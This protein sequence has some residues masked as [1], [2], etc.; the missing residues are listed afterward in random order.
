MRNKVILTSFIIF[1]FIVSGCSSSGAQK[2]VQ[3]TNV[4]PISIINFTFDP[5]TLSIK[6]GTTVT[7]T[8]N[9]LVSHQIKSDSFNSDVLTKGK[10][11]SFTF[12]DIGTYNYSCA[13][14]P[15]MSGQIIVE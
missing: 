13:I 7:W 4:V 10:T 8:N 14:H 12:N 2:N 1:I 6:K 3:T 15:S 11:F 9:D 5:V